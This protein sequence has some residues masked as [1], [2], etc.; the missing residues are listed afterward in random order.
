MSGIDRSITSKVKIKSSYI[1]DVPY[2]KLSDF[3][4]ISLDVKV[5]AMTDKKCMS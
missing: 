5:I 3:K 2:N 4:L 1:L